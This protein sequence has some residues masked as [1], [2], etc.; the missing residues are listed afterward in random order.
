MPLKVA[1]PWCRTV[2]VVS[3]TLRGQVA[4][5]GACGKAMQLGTAPAQPAA[6]KPPPLPA[7]KSAPI[8]FK[9][10][11]AAP[12]PVRAAPPPRRRRNDEDDYDDRPVRPR[13]RRREAAGIPTGVWVCCGVGGLAVVMALVIFVVRAVS[14][15]NDVVRTTPPP[16]QQAEAPLPVQ[17]QEAPQQHQDPPAVVPDPDDLP[18]GPLPAQ[19][20]RDDL[21]RVKKATVYIRAHVPGGMS[22]GTGFFAVQPGLVVTNAHVL[23]MLKSPRP[24]T[25]IDV[26]CDSGEPTERVFPAQLLAYAQNPDLAVLR[27][28]GTN[29]PEPLP[30][31]SAKYLTELQKVYVFGFPF[32]EQLGKNITVSESSV[33][34]L[35]KFDGTDQLKEVQVNGGMQP[36]NSG[37]PVVNTRGHVVGVAVSIIRGT[38]INFAIPGEQVHGFLRDRGIVRR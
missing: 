27:V 37:G 36:G 30:V 17:N 13:R 20:S 6:T 1:C 12:S 14:P 2:S 15:G 31:R 23:N 28:N 33:S 10:D 34:S 25:R 29:L 26:V 18:P 16:G 19:L 5:C 9:K 8:S 22:Q 21:A 11:A 3:D 7:A 24:P 4:K 38:Q 35:R 32:G